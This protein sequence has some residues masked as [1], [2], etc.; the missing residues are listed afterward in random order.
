MQG[1]LIFP[2]KDFFGGV[3]S[4]R[5]FGLEDVYEDNDDEQDES[6]GFDESES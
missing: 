1:L 6:E 3:K 4:L 5:K 2:I